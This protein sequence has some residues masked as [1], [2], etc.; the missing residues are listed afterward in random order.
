MAKAVGEPTATWISWWVA[1][2][3]IAK[4]Y[5]SQSYAERW[6]VERIAAKLVR[7][8]AKATHP[9]GRSL[10]RFWLN[11]ATLTINSE[12]CLATQMMVCDV[13]RSAALENVTLYGL[14]VAREDIEA[15][16][17][18]PPRSNTRDR[19]RAE[20]AHRL[21]AMAIRGDLKVL[22]NEIVGWWNAQGDVRPLKP[23]TVENYIRSL[24]RTYP[25]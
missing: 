6:L 20:A 2:K 12:E 5:H 23:E 4:I 17:P 16:L 8:R 9:P 25:E 1:I 24:W 18:V 13:P 11:P 3:L 7:W 19:V 10:D 22:A 21:D 14:E 15:Q